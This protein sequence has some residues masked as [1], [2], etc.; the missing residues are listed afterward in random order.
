MISFFKVL[1]LKT[2]DN[3]NF[4]Y[5]NLALLKLKKEIKELLNELKDI[6]AIEELN[7]FFKTTKEDSNIRDGY[8]YIIGN[9]S[10]DKESIK[11]LY[12]ILSNGLLDDYSKE[13]MGE[14][15]R[16]GREFI[17]RKAFN[18]VD[19][20]EEVTSYHILD[21]R[22]N[23]L[24]KYINED[25]DKDIVE[26]YIKSQVIHYYISYIHPYFDANGRTA[27]TIA[28][29]YLLNNNADSCVLF[30]NR[31]LQDKQVY[32]RAIKRMRSGN[33]TSYL[34]YS[35]RILKEELEKKKSIEEKHVRR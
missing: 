18:C 21:E 13:H 25:N 7:S 11:K 15:Y 29:W 16:K 22:M 23:N 6:D 20:F 12:A 24:I 5:S 31:M 2:D 34:E 19:E 30:N 14:Y 26:K 3:K 9:N 1:E 28:I 8:C 10:I 4:F 27:R 33:I 35:L 32:N 17:S